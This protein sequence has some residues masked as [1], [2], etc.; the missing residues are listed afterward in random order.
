MEKSIDIIRKNAII[1]ISSWGGL[2]P[3]PGCSS[4]IITN[5]KK[6]YYYHEYYRN[7]QILIDN[8]IPL[9][10][11]SESISISDKDYAKVITFIEQEIVGRTFSSHNI[12]DASFI[13]RVT[14]K[15]KK[16]NIVNNIDY[17]TGEGIYNKV[18]E[19]F[20]NIEGNIYNETNKQAR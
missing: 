17:E 14:Y 20:K 6:L 10:S 13:V 2:G 15:N 18:Q 4:T 11:L 19:L 1:E 9:V 7:S 5:N 16:Y 3:T 12:F 8:N